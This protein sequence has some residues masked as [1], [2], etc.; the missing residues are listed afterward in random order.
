V[1][2]STYLSVD[3]SA[4]PNSAAFRVPNIA[5]VAPTVPGAVAYDTTNKNLHVGANA[6]DNIVAIV[7]SSVSITNNDCAKWTKTGNLVTLDDAGA[8]GVGGAIL[9]SQVSLSNKPSVTLVSTSNLTLSGAQTI[10]G[11]AGTVGTTI[12]LATAQT[13]A[14]QNG[15]WVMQT[16]SWTR[17]TWYPAGG[18]T[19]G[20]QFA[21]TFVRLGTLFQGSTW[22][23]TTAAPI[24][25]D[26]TAT[27]WSQTPLA[28]NSTSVVGN[29]PV[30]NLNNGT[31]A[32]STTFWRG[33]GTWATPAG[34]GISGLTT[35][36]LTKA[37]SAT[38]VGNTLCDEGITTASTLTCTHSGGL[39]IPK[40][41]TSGTNGG[42]DGL[43]GTGA[44][45]TAAANHDLLWSD[46]TAHRWKMNNNNV[47]ADT[48]VGAATADTLTN[49]TIAGAA[50]SGA[51][52][53]TGAYLPVTLMNSGTSASSTTFWRGDGVW[54]TPPGGGTGCNP[55]GVAG[56][57]QASNGSGACQDAG[58]TDDG[59][60]FISPRIFKTTGASVASTPSVLFNGA[61]FTGGTTT[62]TKPLVYIDPGTN[63][64]PTTW[65]AGGTLLGLNSPSGFGGNAIDVHVNGA[66]S[67]FSVNGTGS[68]T[69]ASNLNLGG[70]NTFTFTGRTSQKSPADGI[71]Q[72]T[73][74]AQTGFSRQ[75]YGPDTSSSPALCPS[76]T[77]LLIGVGGANCTTLTTV[78]VA[79]QSA[80]D[81][82]TSAATTAYVD[83][84]VT[85]SL[86]WI[87]G[88]A[89]TGSTLTTAEV[90]YITVPYACTIK[91]YHIMADA[92]TATVKTWR[93]NGGTALPTVSNSISTSGVSLSSGTKVD[94]ATVTDFTST[95]VATN[96]TL[97]F[98]LSS[99]SG[100]KQITFQLDCAQ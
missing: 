60:T 72:L 82:S 78:K 20:V 2:P 79:T 61:L 86:G 40:V 29:L 28:L 6:V 94:S 87:F 32:S 68:G 7:P 22:R 57:L 98:N 18:T 21:T 59:T 53:G 39:V 25:I 84:T 75:T 88:N 42:M 76:T 48:V 81:N 80:D 43:E 100:A 70:A 92:G 90:G 45:L 4:S 63:T 1:T 37:L 5:A 10:D 52:T 14:S 54:A 74:N 96:D 9:D 66:T 35:G 27:A 73:N 83:R 89:V 3:L 91:G 62:T 8:C 58:E 31:G 47:G 85:R 11:Q 34:G 24:T 12:V 93:V 49:K 41:A 95:S 16:A 55:T 77:T 15:P 30:T 19:Q 51:L 38:S 69:F 71:L 23:L 50:V 13:T 36:F 65:V 33:D 64:Q 67:V 56:V 44:L 46:S 26:T 99:V 17:P 97:G